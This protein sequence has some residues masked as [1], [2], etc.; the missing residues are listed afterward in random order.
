VLH[1]AAGALFRCDDYPLAAQFAQRAVMLSP[2]RLDTW[3]LLV[4][5]HLGSGAVAAA[6]NALDE[7]R[8]LAPKDERIV[9]LE[10]KLR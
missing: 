4:Y 6:R 10:Q 2:G 7:A 5:I 8:R 1:K 9:R 3:L